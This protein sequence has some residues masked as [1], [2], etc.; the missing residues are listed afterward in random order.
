M[1]FEPTT[2]VLKKLSEVCQLFNEESNEKNKE[3]LLIN[4]TPTIKYSNIILP[5]DYVFQS[6]DNVNL[7][8][9]YYYLYYNLD[10]LHNDIIE[11][12]VIKFPPIKRQLYT[13]EYLDYIDKSIITANKLIES[14]KLHKERYIDIQKLLKIKNQKENNDFFERQ[15]S[16]IKMSEKDI[17]LHK[18][19]AKNFMKNIIKTED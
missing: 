8:Y 17:E 10:L 13:V 3:Y 9:I 5:S 6:L 1:D 14:C 4:K 16:L 2:V 12:V 7:K 15:D 11:N 19:M 18:N